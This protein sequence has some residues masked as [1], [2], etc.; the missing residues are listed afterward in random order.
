MFSE[1]SGEATLF[2]ADGQTVR[3]T[4]YLPR[5]AQEV[6]R[7]RR[8]DIL[9]PDDLMY[10]LSLLAKLMP[11]QDEAAALNKMPDQTA[12]NFN[13]ENIMGKS[14]GFWGWL[15]NTLKL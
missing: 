12:P 4:I 11:K 2:L 7:Q 3:R 6:V 14:Q 5:D 13:V 10:N 8:P 1:E 9:A 15:K